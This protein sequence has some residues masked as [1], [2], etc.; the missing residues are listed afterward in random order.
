MTVPPRP[1]A[2]SGSPADSETVP[3]ADADASL[4]SLAQPAT[5]PPISRTSPPAVTWRSV[6]ISVLLLPVNDY[7]QIQMEMVRNSTHPTTLSLLF[8]VIFLLLCIT[9]INRL[10]GY[11][12]PL[13]VL[14]RGELLFIYSALAVGAAVCGADMLQFLVPMLTY[15]FRF[16]DGANGWGTLINPRLPSA[17]FVEDP[18]VYNAYYDGGATLWQLSHLRVWLPVVLAWTAFAAVLLWVMLC[19]CAILRRAWTVN[20]KL[21]YPIVQLPLQITDETSWQRG[22]TFRTRAFWI[23]FALAGSVD[24]LNSLNYWFPTIPAIGVPGD[25]QSFVDIGPLFTEKPWSALGWTPLS[26]YPFLI[27][28]GIFMPLD[29]LF[30]VGFFYWF[31]KLQKVAT[32]ALAYD[33]TGRFPYV[34]N[35]AFGAYFAFCLMSLWISRGYLR[36]VWRKATGQPSPLDDAGEPMTYRTAVWGGLAGIALLVGF[37][38]WIGMTWWVAAL[39]FVM[40]FALA[41]AITRM[42]AELGTPVHDLHFTG[43]EMILTHVAG[44]RA[45]DGGNLVGFALFFWFNRAY[46][47]HPMPHLLESFKLAQEAGSD[48]RR[49]AAALAIL[50]VL[51]VFIGIWVIISLMYEYGAAGQVR[52]RPGAETFRNLAAW[53]ANPLPG[54]P[55]ELGAVGVGFAVTLLLQ[56]LRI[57]V[58]GFA[59]HPLAFAVTS[60]W[61]INTVWLPLSIAWLI[62]VLLLRFGG[63]Y[64]F[65]RSIPFFIGLMLGQFVVGGVWN[66]LGTLIDTP[67]YRF[68]D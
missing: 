7:W 67:T 11:F 14:G 15:S 51:A 33:Q 55:A 34:E 10:I 35:Q 9:G 52:Y 62:K 38:V 4:E 27:G 19:L 68:W 61:Q 63:L 60:S 54:Q 44:S 17:L 29:F 16:A 48:Y 21:T 23:G 64:A 57:W 53:L 24:M 6:L 3:K 65:R 47:S 50:Q 22:G 1:R 20:E 32:V 2:I 30:S 66:I 58:P 41:L 42:R 36:D 5:V 31:W 26:F 49:W 43:P 28:L 59:L 8:N 56:A 45:F 40:Y 25:G 39:F 18:M 46:R 12:A 37:A 13:Q